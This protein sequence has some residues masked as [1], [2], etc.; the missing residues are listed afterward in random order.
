MAYKICN[1]CVMDTSDPSI[2]FDENGNVL[3]VIL[4]MQ[5][6]CQF[7]KNYYLIKKP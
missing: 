4:S 6:L 2:E 5:K 7:G 3:I 1:N